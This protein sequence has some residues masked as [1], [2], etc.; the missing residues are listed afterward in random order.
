MSETWETDSRWRRMRVSNALLSEVLRGNAVSCETDAPADLAIIGLDEG[1]FG[2][3]GECIF[4]VWSA[5]FEP[6]P[7]DGAGR[8]VVDIPY[9]EFEYRPAIWERPRDMETAP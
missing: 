7:L 9:V 2:P 1:K 3:N 8:L 4:V 6:Q 5:S